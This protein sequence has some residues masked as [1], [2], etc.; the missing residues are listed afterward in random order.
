MSVFTA[1]NSFNLLIGKTGTFEALATV[2]IT[3]SSASTYIDDG[4]I[5]AVNSTGTVLAPGSTISDSPFIKLVQR[6]GS[7]L[8]YSDVIDGQAVMSYSGVAGAAAVEQVNTIGF[9][10]TAGAIDTTALSRFLR[11]TYTFDFVTWSEQPFRRSYQTTS[12]VQANMIADIVPAMNKDSL[13][14][15]MGE[16][17]TAAGFIS[18]IA[19]CSNAGT[20]ITGTGNISVVKGSP[21]IT[22]ATDIDAVMAVG[23]WIRINSTATTGAMYKIIAMNTTANT[24]TLFCPYQGATATIAEASNEYVSAANAILAN[25]GI[26]MTGLP[27]TFGLWPYS[28]FEY[29]KVSFNVGTGTDWGTTPSAS[30]TAPSFGVG[31]YE[32]VAEMEKFAAGFDGAVNRTIVPFPAGRNDAVSG[33]LYDTIFIKHADVSDVDVI[34]GIKPSMK[35]VFIF[36]ADGAA[37]QAALLSQLNPWMASTPKSLPNIGAL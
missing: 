37:Q 22:A 23:D 35:E 6:S 27:L 14:A 18:A 16:G 2:Q 7:K 12:T 4:Q 11:I 28:D 3:D 31:V 34:D 9:N 24:A 8:I 15:L 1:K 19:M 29:N 5:I 30:V 17:N 21:T 13:N 26:Q 32:R 20:A 10:G 36:I 25:W 33:T